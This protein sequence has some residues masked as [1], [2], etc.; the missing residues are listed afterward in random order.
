[1]GQCDLVLLSEGLCVVDVSV[2]DV[3]VLV[4]LMVVSMLRECFF[5]FF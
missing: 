5:V 2:V 4:G 1:M 3:V